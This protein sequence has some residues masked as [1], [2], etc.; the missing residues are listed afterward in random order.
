MTNRRTRF[1]TIVSLLCLFAWQRGSARARE[2]EENLENHPR[3]PKFISRRASANPLA[4]SL[5]N[6]GM[7]SPADYVRSA[8]WL[9]MTHRRG[10]Y[11]LLG[12]AVSIVV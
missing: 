6:F 8:S 10:W 7:I 11:V 3:E 1:A 9:A 4:N 5:R 12:Q 2:P